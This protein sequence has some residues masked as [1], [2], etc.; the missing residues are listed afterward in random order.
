MTEYNIDNSFDCHVLNDDQVDRCSA[1]N[2]EVKKLAHLIRDLCPDSRERSLALTKL[3]EC[4]FWFT[5][6]IGRNV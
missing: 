2:S 3:E 6:A 4:A 5:D 1:L